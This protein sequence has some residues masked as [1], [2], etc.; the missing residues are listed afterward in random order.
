M[1]FFK[2]LVFIFCVGIYLGM[3]NDFYNV[4][5]AVTKEVIDKN[6]VSYNGWLKVDGNKLVNQ[7][8]E[9]VQ[10]KGLSTHGVQWFRNIYS[11]DN[12]K[13]LKDDWGINVF[14]VAMYTEPIQDGYIKNKDLKNEIISI[15]DEAISLDLYVVI[16]WHIL[17]DGDPTKYQDE[18]IKFFDEISK[19]YKDTPNV[20]FEIC[21]EPNGEQLKWEKVKK[22][23][24]KVISTI[25]KNAPDSIIIVGT[26]EWCKDIIPIINNPLNFDNIMYSVHF[27]AGTDGKELRDKMDKL[28]DKQL[29]IF[30][31]EC[32]IT[33]NTGD[34]RI[35]ETEFNEWI[36]YINDKKLSWIFWSFSNKNENSSVLDKSYNPKSSNKDNNFNNYLSK[37]GTII[38]SIFQKYKEEN[39]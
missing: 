11:Y 29:P 28:L 34:S 35:Y 5:D 37:T 3:N 14:R 18:A 2:M 17:F 20:I 19:K 36:D 9:E 25:R 27:Y 30:I 33:D 8:N 10:L 12:I 26:P 32:G 31:S 39:Y 38:K 4:N 16:D 24:E 21:N 23:A 15:V 7:N 6:T 22:Y 13:I 1:N